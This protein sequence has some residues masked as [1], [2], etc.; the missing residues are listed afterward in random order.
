MKRV[1]MQGRGA[2]E[3]GAVQSEEDHQR[4]MNGETILYIE[5]QGMPRIAFGH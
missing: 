2:G 3:M 5:W 1:I 4:V